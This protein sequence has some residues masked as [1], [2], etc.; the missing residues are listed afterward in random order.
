MSVL[1]R[2]ATVQCDRASIGKVFMTSTAISVENLWKQFRLYHNKNQYLKTAILQGGRSRYEE[3][4]ALKDISFEV[5]QGS[6]FGIIGSNG[7]GKSTMLK[8]LTGILTPDRGQIQVHGRIAALLELG[9][10]F[11][12]DLSGRENIFLNGAILGMTSKE[13]LRKM[14]EIISFAGLEQF[15]D[16]PVKNYS[17]GMT[18]RLGFAIAINVDPEILIIDEVLAVGD[19][20][21]QKKCMEKIEDFRSD[22]RTIVFVSHGVGQVAQ[23]CDS[24]AWIEKGVLQELGEAQSVVENY[25]ALSYEALP[26]EAD[27]IGQRW[28]SG[29]VTITSVKMT[30]K[31]GAT[32]RLFHTGDPLLISIEFDSQVELANSSVAVRIN[33][34]HGTDVW[35]TSTDMQS[36]TVPINIGH[37]QIALKLD[38]LPLLSGTYDLSVVIAD[39]AAIHEFDHWEKRVRFDINQQSI[40]NSGLV[41]IESEWVIKK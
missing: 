9:A 22:G 36:F 2:K 35:G 16:T 12:P 8:C 11:H 31:T 14:E 34:L 10:G 29:E 24:V 40:S 25:N 23:I 39:H 37:G 27:D 32:E 6:T 3:F 41:N 4:W 13:I 19:A 1:A 17:S 30:N 7:S 26:N 5:P 18:V 21:F 38:H 28:G 20:A 33:H 15:I